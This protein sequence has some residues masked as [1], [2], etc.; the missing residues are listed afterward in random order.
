MAQDKRSALV[1]EDNNDLAKLMCLHLRSIAVDSDIASSGLQALELYQHNQYDM[2]LLDLMLPELDG[3][4]VCKNIRSTNQQIPIMMLTAKAEELD[5]VVGLDLGADDYLTKP[6][7]VAEFT[8]R[9]KALLR[10]SE[11]PSAELVDPLLNERFGK[12]LIDRMKREVILDGRQI[13]LTVREFALLEY[14][15]RHPGQAFSRTQLLEHVWGYHNN[16]YRHTV[17]SHINRL[18]AKIE[19]DPANP[20]IVLT[21][22]GIGYKLNEHA[23]DE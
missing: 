14:L 4:E 15:V 19:T 18:R 20:K 22:W 16:V 17:N 2:V 23:F 1:V 12:I 21:V 11:L 5:K 6:F 9:V 7:G 10:R 13:D 8:A 3:L